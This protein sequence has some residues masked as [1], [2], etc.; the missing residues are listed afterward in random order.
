MLTHMLI[1]DFVQVKAP[2]AMVRG[3]LLE[4]HPRWLADD[5]TAAYA[6]AR[7]LHM[8]VCATAAELTIRKRVRSIWAPPPLAVTASSFR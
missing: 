3:H 1:Q 5:A 7:R 8:T 6:E 4:P 2:Y